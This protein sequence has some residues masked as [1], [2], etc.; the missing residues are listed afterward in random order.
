M[1][2]LLEGIILF[3][4]EQFKSSIHD[5]VKGNC[6]THAYGRT[7]A[8]EISKPD[9]KFIPSVYKNMINRLEPGEYIIE[10]PVFRSLLNLKFP[11]P[12]YRQ[13]PNG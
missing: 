7:N 13:Y 6:A 12:I 10:H 3:S 1:F 5:R 9:Y 8:I 11:K 2:I 4:V